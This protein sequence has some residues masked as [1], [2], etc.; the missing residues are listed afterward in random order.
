MKST[1]RRQAPVLAQFPKLDPE[2]PIGP[3]TPLHRFG[4]QRHLQETSIGETGF[5]PATARPPAGTIQACG[6][7]LGAVERCSLLSVDL[8]FAQFVPQDVPQRWPPPGFV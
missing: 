5:E 4:E 6:L 3:E 2:C 8:S 1:L 7:T